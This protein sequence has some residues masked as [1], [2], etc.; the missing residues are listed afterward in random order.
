LG[1]VPDGIAQDFAHLL[2][3]APT[4]SSSTLLELRFDVVVEVANGA[5]E[6]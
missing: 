3:G 4:V 6:P 2:F 1:V 5:A